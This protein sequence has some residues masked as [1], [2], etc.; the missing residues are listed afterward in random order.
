MPRRVV[1]PWR[2]CHHRPRSARSSWRRVPRL[3]PCPSRR[4]P[5]PFRRPCPF[6]PPCPSLRPPCPCRRRPWPAGRYRLRRPASVR[7]WRW[8]PVSSCWRSNPSWPPTGRSTHAATTHSCWLPG[9]SWRG[10]AT[11]CRQPCRPTCD[12]SP[13]STPTWGSNWTGWTPR[14]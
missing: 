7:A 11:A 9:T 6:R 10:P 12:S 14:R 13:G 8:C 5:C 1:G 4:P 2:R 3:R